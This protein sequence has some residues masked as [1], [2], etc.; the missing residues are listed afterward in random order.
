MC[1]SSITCL[2]FGL[3]HCFINIQIPIYKFFALFSLQMCLQDVKVPATAG[4][5]IGGIMD[6][7]RGFS[8][9]QTNG[10]PCV[11]Y[12]I[13]RGPDTTGRP[14]SASTLELRR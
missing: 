14:A 9:K 1:Y 8:D 3:T 2:G 11:Y 7:G 5:M 4:C 6:Q 13:S 12:R 10:Q